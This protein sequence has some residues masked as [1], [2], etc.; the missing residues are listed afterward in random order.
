MLLHIT[1]S[2]IANKSIIDL[3]RRDVEVINIGASIIHDAVRNQH[4]YNLDAFDT[5]H[6][7]SAQLSKC[8][9]ILTFDKDLLNARIEP[10][11]R[12]LTSDDEFIS[13]K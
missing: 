10:K 11:A 13:K 12:K 4:R 8:T 9:E 3:L 1:G 5:F 2:E 6:V 7:I